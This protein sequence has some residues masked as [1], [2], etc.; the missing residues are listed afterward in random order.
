MAP[1]AGNA[2]RGRRQPSVPVRRRRAAH[3]ARRRLDV[4]VAVQPG[5][6]ERRT[7]DRRGA[8]SVESR[9]F[10]RA[11][12]GR[13]DAGVSFGRRVVIT[14]GNRRSARTVDPHGPDS[15][16]VGAGGRTRLGG[17]PAYGRVHRSAS[18]HRHRAFPVRRRT[19]ARHPRRI[20]GP[21]RI[22]GSTVR[23]P[24]RRRFASST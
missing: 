21:S 11:G 16:Q 10:A 17:A 13:L 3:A 23:L 24:G 1:L 6:D 4:G 5:S 18:Q 7:G 8:A 20:V 22:G 12:M 14:R 19:I 9:A 2:W 15:A